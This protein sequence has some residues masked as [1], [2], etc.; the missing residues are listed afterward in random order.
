VLEKYFNSIEFDGLSFFKSSFIIVNVR[1]QAEAKGKSRAFLF[2]NDDGRVYEKETT[3]ESRTIEVHDV[4][5]RVTSRTRA[6]FNMPIPNLY[7]Q[8]L[9]SA[10]HNV[11]LRYPAFHHD[12][13]NNRILPVEGEHLCL[14]VKHFERFTA[15]A[16]RARGRLLGGLYSEISSLF[17]DISFAVPSDSYKNIFFIKPNREAGYSDQF[18]SGESA[19]APVQKEVFTA[20]YSEYFKVTR[21]LSNEEAINLTFNGGDEKLTIRNYGDDNSLSGQAT[22]LSA[23]TRF[24]SE[25][26]HVEP[27]VPPKFLGFVWYE[28]LGWRLPPASYLLKTYLNE[29]RPYS[30]FRRFPNLGWVEKRHIFEKLG[31]PYV[32]KEIFPRENIELARRGLPWSDI[33]W[34]GEQER[35]Q[36]ASNPGQLLPNFILGKDYALTAQEKLQTGEFIGL[37]PEKTSK[38]IK[39]LVDTTWFNLTRLR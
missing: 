19:V 34:R 8:V 28:G 16:V 31:H 9:D 30:N 2:V 37:L 21:A 12:M 32:A 18:S 5:R 10:I 1:L 35:I 36:A 24:L 11:F 4:G 15:D 23:V 25:Y 38:M 6:I 14:D 22:E 29:R 20:L 39:R 17:A 26:L 3:E 13:F 33:V 27:E 7:K